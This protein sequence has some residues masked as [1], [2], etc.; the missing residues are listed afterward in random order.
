M[1]NPDLEKAKELARDYSIIPVYKEILADAVTPINILRKIS[2][3]SQRYFL[4]ESVEGG[5]RW[6]R[7]S[8]IGRKPFLLLFL[9]WTS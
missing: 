9:R 6:A 7:Y 1:I 3:I 4:L 8:Y 2:C 5:E